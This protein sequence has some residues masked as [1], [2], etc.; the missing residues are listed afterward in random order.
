MIGDSIGID[1]DLH[2]AFLVKQ[3]LLPTRTL[4]EAKRKSA[5]LGTFSENVITDTVR[6]S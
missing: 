4:T 5:P 1:D 3:L 6:F 2:F